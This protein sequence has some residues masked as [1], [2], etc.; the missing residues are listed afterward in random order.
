MILTE[1]N[2]IFTF[3][4]DDDSQLGREQGLSLDSNAIDSTPLPVEVPAGETIKQMAGGYGS[5]AIV[6]ESG[7]IYWWGMKWG[8][9]FSIE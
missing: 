7:N 9:S 4:R 2:K 5:A 8:V 1:D 6:C 3:G